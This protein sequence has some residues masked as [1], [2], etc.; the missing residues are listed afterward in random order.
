MVPEK[1]VGGIQLYDADGLN[2]EFMKAFSVG[3]IPR[4]MMIDGEGKIITA[5]APRPSSD[6]VRKF[7]DGHLEKPIPGA[8]FQRRP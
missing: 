5:Q 4:F 7:I 1:N 6:D 8:P 2:S 3:L